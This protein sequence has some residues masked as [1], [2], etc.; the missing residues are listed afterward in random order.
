MKFL[1]D[2]Y[3]W[4]ALVAALF[5]WSGLYAWVGADANYQ[6]PLNEPLMFL[7]FALLY[8]V[9]EE[10]V[11]RGL[12]Q[13]SL[14]KQITKRFGVLTIA[15]AITSLLFAASHFFYHAPI[16]SAV[17]I[18][19]SLLFGF[20]KERHRSLLPPILLHVFYNTGYYVIFFRPT[21]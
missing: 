14:A 3:Y 7:K 13:D 5:F 6:W 4:A 17:I 15:N 12:V 10:I 1:R 18:L 16:W 2:K 20:F 11:F 19:P 21:P 9:F 8:P